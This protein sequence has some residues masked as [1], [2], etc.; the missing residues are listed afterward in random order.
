MSSSRILFPQFRDEQSDS[1]YPFVDYATLTSPAANVKINPNLFVDASFFGI[2]L[3]A[4]VYISSITVATS[5]VTIRVGDSAGA[6]KLATTF[7]LLTPPEDGVL[8]F[9]DAFGRPGGVLLSDPDAGG[10]TALSVFSSWPTG[11]HTFTAAAT[12]FVATVV[13]PAAEPGVRGLVVEDAAESI[14]TGDVWLVGRGGVVLR[15]EDEQTIRV[16]I[17]G[18]PLFKRF[19]CAPQTE[20]A[21]KNFLQ[22]INNC[23]PDDFGNFIFTATDKDTERPVLR[24]YANNDT[25]VFSAAGPSVT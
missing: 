8:T 9:T 18:V 4:G 14:L 23:G 19:V 16:D 5:T 25:L 15:A 20:F 2:G 12:E 13:V 24:V 21:T 17:V 11:T 7:A 6:D 3:G 22:T 1:K 10:D